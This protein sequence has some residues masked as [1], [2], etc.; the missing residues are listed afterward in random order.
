MSYVK[1]TVKVAGKLV[2]AQVLR[3]LGYY[4]E[5][6]GKWKIFH[7]VSG[8]VFSDQTT[9]KW[10]RWTLQYYLDKYPE[11][12]WEKEPNMKAITLRILN[13]WKEDPAR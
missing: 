8:H 2:E 4:R 12:D 6:R 1:Q 10:A 9:E 7:V 5:K 3:G 13:I 11:I